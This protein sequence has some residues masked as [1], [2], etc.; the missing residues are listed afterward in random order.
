MSKWREEIKVYADIG[1]ARELWCYK[2][3]DEYEEKIEQLEKQIEMMKN[4]ENCENAVWESNWMYSEHHCEQDNCN[5][6]NKW[7][8][9]K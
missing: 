8:M 9:K 4:C 3:L 6:Y 5:N 1:M 7:E 2:K